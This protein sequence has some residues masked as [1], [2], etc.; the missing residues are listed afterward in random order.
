MSILSPSP[1]ALADAIAHL[2]AGRLVAFPTETVYGLGADATN[3]HAVAGIYAAKHRPQFNPLIAHVADAAAAAA[4]V[5]MDARAW[6]LA[7]A[8]W[9]GPLTL[10][11]PRRADCPVSLLAGAGLDSL[12]VRV[13]A[14]PIALAL[15]R[16]C[17]LPLAAPSANPSGAVSPTT[18]AHVQAGLGGKVAAILEGGP[19]L[20]GIESTILDLTGPHAR[21][22]RPGGL[23]VERIEALIGPILRPAPI[24]DDAAPLAPGLLRS[25]YAPGLPVRLNVTAPAP[26]E[27]WLGFGPTGARQPTLSLSPTGDLT[28]AAAHLFAMLRQL[29]Q[30]DRYRAIA[31]MPIPAHG[32][33]LGI[34]DRLERAAAPRGR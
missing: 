22:L 14:H 28:E 27:A 32:L 23:A 11:L 30:P 3:D 24:V 33:G 9:P 18:A 4:L 15:L 20:V 7:G 26:D 10:V 5:V 6:A 16:G 21:L 19:C 8:F 29:D 1:A 2:R 34:N 31:V 25:H 12:A 17:G 13:P